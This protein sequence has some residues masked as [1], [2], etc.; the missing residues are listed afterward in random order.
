MVLRIFTE[1]PESVGETYGEHF[2]QAS[3]FGSKMIA[4][5]I[6]CV[7]HGLFPFLF[8]HTGSDAVKSLHSTMANR[9]AGA[10]AHLGAEH[11]VPR[12]LAVYQSDLSI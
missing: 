5:G 3:T 9:R 8:K 4:A 11:G 2:M 7:L 12:C 1:H 10:D 6:C